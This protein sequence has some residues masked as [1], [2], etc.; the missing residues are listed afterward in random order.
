M[1]VTTSTASRTIPGLHVRPGPALG[2]CPA[3][4]HAVD[5]DASAVRYRDDWYHIRCALDEDKGIAA[6]PSIQSC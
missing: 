4:G 3:C 1:A 5:P 2:E 6:D